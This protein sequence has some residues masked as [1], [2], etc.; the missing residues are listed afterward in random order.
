MSFS[1]YAK[2][3]V[4][5]HSSSDK[6]SFTRTAATKKIASHYDNTPLTAADIADKLAAVSSKYVI[7]ANPE[8]FVYVAVRALT[9]DVPNEN[10]DAFSEKELLSINAD[11][12]CRTYQTFNLKPH[13]INHRSED[14]TQARGVILD[15][16]Y[17]TQNDEHFPEILI[18]VD[19]TKDARLA[20]GIASGE[21]NSFSMGCTAERTICSVCDNEANSP[22]EFCNH[23]KFDKGKEIEGSKVFEWCE[24]VTFEEESS[25]D[26]PAD[27]TALTQEVILA[28]KKDT[29]KTAL[30]LESTV[31]AVDKNIK[32]INNSLQNIAE[33]L[34]TANDVNKDNEDAQSTVAA[35]ETKKESAPA[36]NGGLIP[37]DDDDEE[38]DD[39]I[40]DYKETLEDE[41]N[42]KMTD[43]EYGIKTSKD[44][45]A[46]KKEA[47]DSSAKSFWTNY[48]KDYGEALTRPQK[49]KKMSKKNKDSKQADQG[50]TFQKL[51]KAKGNNVPKEFKFADK[52]QQFTKIDKGSGNPPKDFTIDKKK[53]NPPKEFK[54][55]KLHSDVDVYPA[56]SKYWLVAKGD[57]PRYLLTNTADNAKKFA[58]SKESE[59]EF[60]RQLIKDIVSTGL[61][62]TMEANNALRIRGLYAPDFGPPSATDSLENDLADSYEKPTGGIE[63]GGTED[64]DG[65]DKSKVKDKNTNDGGSKDLKASATKKTADMVALLDMIESETAQGKTSEEILE[66]VEGYIAA[67][68]VASVQG[69]LEDIGDDTLT[70]MVSS[71]T[72]ETSPVELMAKI[73]AYSKEK[74][75]SIAADSVGDMKEKITEATADIVAEGTNDLDGVAPKAQSDKVFNKGTDDLKDDRGG[76]ANVKATRKSRTPVVQAESLKAMKQKI[77]EEVTQSVRQ[78][79]EKEFAE[80]REAFR[81]RFVRAMHLASARADLNL[82]D[83]ELKISFADALLSPVGDYPGMDVELATH[84][85]EG[86]FN[87]CGNNYVDSLFK[88]A[89]KFLKMSDESFLQLEEDTGTLNVVIPLGDVDVDGTIDMEDMDY[90]EDYIDVDLGAD[91][92]EELDDLVEQASRSNPVIASRTTSEHRSKWSALDGA[93]KNK[94]A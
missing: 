84:L 40:E 76:L 23:I 36:E 45:G 34:T 61:S 56:T 63:T 44:K 87:D 12:G 3:T 48:F 35:E 91:S 33:Q 89:E 58:E 65:V 52:G 49:R 42:D 85:I 60:A 66:M 55:A 22:G 19:K 2:A 93:F 64:L 38:E 53:G 25:V 67:D 28:S 81:V 73:I 16:H 92:D 75:A 78:D 20:E 71:A 43:G 27:K 83:N 32:D 79:L 47:L 77:A 8:D 57:K 88:E 31:M 62:T 13:H 15:S 70:E 54:F 17:N 46:S 51:D 94:L 11:M 90:D 24:G 10:L 59:G 1:K 69:E 82:V 74:K 6:S 29:D 18:A 14:P 5:A 9:A 21:L 7:S 37:S 50:K 86:A 80:H 30:E 41:E 39:V 72:E 26:D 68:A 4:L